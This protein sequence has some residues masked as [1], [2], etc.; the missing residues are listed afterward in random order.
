[1]FRTMSRPLKR[2]FFTVVDTNFKGI[3]LRLGKNSGN[4]DSGFHLYI[5]FI[6]EIHLIDMSER[7]EKLKYQTLISKDNVSVKLDSSIQYQVTNPYKAL[8][9]V[10]DFKQTIL[11]RA[12]V[13]IRETVSSSSINDLLHNSGNVRKSILNNIGD[14]EHWGIKIIG[15]NIKDIIFDDS[16]KKSMATVAE[17]NRLADAK[18]INARADIETAKLYKEAAALYDDEKALKLREFQLLTT[19]SHNP[20]STIYFYPSDIAQM[21]KK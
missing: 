19:L 16:M 10:K 2:T 21:F 11:E 6:D 1:M 8:F 3:R 12:S 14:T 20:A 13:S 4:I 9:D 17:A 18:I 5:P 7:V 15:V